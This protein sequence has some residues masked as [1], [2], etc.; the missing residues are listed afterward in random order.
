MK[1]RMFITSICFGLLFIS[2][3]DEIESGLYTVKG[4]IFNSNSVAEGTEVSIDGL[5]NWTTISDENGYFEISGINEGI[6]NLF[7]S[8]QFDLINDNENLTFS[9]K[10]YEIAVYEDVD[11]DDLILPD[12]VLLYPLS[13]NDNNG[14]EIAW[15][16]T[17]DESFREYKLY[18][19]TTSGIDENSGTLAHVSTSV[20]DTTF[21]DEDVVPGTEYFYRVYVMNDYGK[22]GGSHIESIVTTNPNI[23]VNG[24]FETM[25][26]DLPDGWDYWVSYGG[27]PFSLDSDIAFEGIYSLKVALNEGN[28]FDNV[29]RYEILTD[30]ITLGSRYQLS[31]KYKHTSI[32]ES[33]QG[34][35]VTLNKNEWSEWILNEKVVSGPTDEIDWVEYTADVIFPEDQTI[36]KYT[37][38]MSFVIGDNFTGETIDFWIDNVEMK[39][40][41]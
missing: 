33:W 32:N 22:L 41:E 11:L 1:L 37:L 38:N 14:I 3:D 30:E 4:T 6:H 29:L 15:S 10:S 13:I 2:C 34:I 35:R 27:F 18:R 5:S 31:F 23:I 24:N 26:N 8:K 25:T 12:P 28:F 40:K 20:N 9:E 7:I 36:S 17:N 16:P 21:V 39:L 19:H